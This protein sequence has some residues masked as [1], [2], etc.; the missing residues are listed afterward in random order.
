ME[1]TLTENRPEME[2]KPGASVVY[3]LVGKCNIVSIETRNIGQETVRF[4]KLEIQKSPL[5]RS[6]KKEPAILL[7][8]TTAKNRG[9]RSPM[10]MVEAENVLKIFESREYFFPI[11]KPWSA[12]HHDLEKCIEKEGSIGLAKVASYL[13]V[14]KQ[15]QIVP[16]TEVLRFSE[17]VSKIL[18]RELSEV[19]QKPMKILEDEANK[20]LRH[21]LVPDN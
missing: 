12:V 8:V 16:S 9:L 7:P 10:D 2:F 4:Y 13:H 5:S 17:N 15:K 14:L 18:F 20:L 19:F 6:N 3:A 11:E 1:N 21:K